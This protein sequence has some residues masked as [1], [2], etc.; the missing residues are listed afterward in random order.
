MK[1]VEDSRLTRVSALCLALPEALR[2]DEVR[3]LVT[4][5]YLRAAPKKLAAVVE[6]AI[7]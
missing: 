2:A 5:S 3:D 7:S 1:A 6:A 4:A